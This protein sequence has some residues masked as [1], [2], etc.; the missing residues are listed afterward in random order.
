M[1]HLQV[2]NNT[3]MTKFPTNFVEMVCH[4]SHH[5]SLEKQKITRNKDILDKGYFI[6]I[7]NI[8]KRTKFADILFITQ[9]FLHVIRDNW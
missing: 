6:C 2:E 4:L 1:P 7:T 9:Q 8:Y 3:A 5:F